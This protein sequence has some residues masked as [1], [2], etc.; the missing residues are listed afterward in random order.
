MKLNFN[1]RLGNKMTIFTCLEFCGK[2][3]VKRL[4]RNQECIHG[5][6]MSK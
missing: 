5:K 6:G 1:L 4:K 3:Q 2:S